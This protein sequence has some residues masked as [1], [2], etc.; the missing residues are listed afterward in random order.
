LWVITK[1]QPYLP[2]I[3]ALVT[4]D[5]AD[6]N[7]VRQDWENLDQKTNSHVS[8]V[9]DAVRGGLSSPLVTE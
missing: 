3:V 1:L 2:F 5:G 4:L 7:S 8:T 6:M 9:S